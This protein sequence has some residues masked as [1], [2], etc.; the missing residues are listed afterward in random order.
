MAY[1][2]NIRRDWDLMSP[3]VRDFYR[4]QAN[5]YTDLCRPPYTLLGWS[6]VRYSGYQLWNHNAK[7]QAAISGVW[8]TEIVIFVTGDPAWGLDP[9][10]PIDH[11]FEVP[12]FDQWV[13]VPA[14]ALEYP[15]AK[16]RTVKH[17]WT[18]IS[19]PRRNL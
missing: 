1:T 19:R 18:G 3:G 5:H 17:Y 4:W 6:A 11:V 16:V 7:L 12:L 8:D 13:A 10:L 15:R 2:G 14:Q 9:S